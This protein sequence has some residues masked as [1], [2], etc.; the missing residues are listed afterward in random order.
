MKTQ[1]QTHQNKC[2]MAHGEMCWAYKENACFQ[3]QEWHGIFTHCHA[4]ERRHGNS[5]QQKQIDDRCD[6]SVDVV[7]PFKKGCIP[8][9]VQKLMYNYGKRHNDAC[10][11]MFFLSCYLIGHQAEQEDSHA[12]INDSP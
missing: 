12:E 10:P 11:F 9:S 2:P 1:M 8:P 3:V 6:G 5:C 7:F 4:A